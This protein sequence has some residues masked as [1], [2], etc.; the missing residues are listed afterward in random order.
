MTE[1]NHSE[2]AE[3]AGVLQDKG[4]FMG[5]PMM[6]VGAS[7]VVAFLFLVTLGVVWAVIVFAGAFGLLRSAHRTDPDGARIWLLRLRRGWDGYAFGKV[8]SP[9]NFVKRS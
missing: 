2:A 1:P 5:V 3:V 8:P 9:I 7:A 4:T 6:W